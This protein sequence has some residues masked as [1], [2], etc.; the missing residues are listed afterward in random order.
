MARR[1]YSQPI[2][3]QFQQKLFSARIEVPFNFKHV[4]YDEKQYDLADMI[5]LKTR[6]NVAKSQLDP[7][8]LGSRDNAQL[9]R[10]WM[11]FQNIID[12]Y[13][14]MRGKIEKTYKAEH[15][16]NAWMK[17]WE[18]YSHYGVICEQK[19]ASEHQLIAFF[20]AELPGAALCAFLHYMRAMKPTVAYDWFAS[21]LV[22]GSNDGTEK[23]GNPGDALGDT[24]GLWRQNKE[25]WLM[26]VGDGLAKNNG[27]STN[28]KNINDFAAR[29]GVKSPNHGVD[30]YSHDAG[31]D[32]STDFN[33][34][35]LANARIH[36]G[37][38]LAGFKT[39]RVGG[40]F[41]AKQYTFFETITW[42]LI[43]IY[44]QLFDE[45]YICKPLT[46]RPYNSEV[47][48]IGKGFRGLPS[49]IETILT[50]KLTTFS[51]TPLIPNDAVSVIYGTAVGAIL[52]AARIIFG[53]QISMLNE[54]VALFEKYKTR[55]SML[56]SG[57]EDMKLERISAW[58]ATNKVK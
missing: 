16:T 56:K 51:T 36:L 21:S 18:I 19:L 38:A 11:F 40:N 4:V 12:I 33:D 46:S 20:N 30:L 6:L 47:Y 2:N 10:D 45:F 15:V 13:K 37:C 58:L 55:L 44:A 27:D 31:I 5:E 57:L 3:K 35:E 54:N 1:Q 24:Y 48:L 28:I 41:I 29:I 53:Q 22:P 34:Q 7:Y 8:Y 14:D 52:R 26:N 39:L 43:L 25:K 32:V 17:Y 9:K 49:E 42:N 23:K 50:N